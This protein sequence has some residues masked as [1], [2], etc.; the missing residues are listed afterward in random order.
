MKCPWCV[1]E[2]KR[3]T[4]T[5]LASFRTA[6]GWEP[7]YDEDGRYHTHDPNAGA[8]R[9]MCS[10]GHDFLATYYPCNSCNWGYKEAKLISDR[11]SNAWFSTV[12]HPSQS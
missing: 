4:L 6:M 11:G 1:K 5:P 12:R 2:D 3:S 9:F 7:Y 10:R 8:P